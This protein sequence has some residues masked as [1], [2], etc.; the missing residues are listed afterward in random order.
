MWL[1]KDVAMCY[2]SR[3][4]IHDPCAKDVLSALRQA[5]ERQCATARHQRLEPSNTMDVSNCWRAGMLLCFW[6]NAIATCSDAVRTA[7]CRPA[8]SGDQCRSRLLAPVS[9]AAYRQIDRLAQTS[10][11]QNGQDAPSMSHGAMC[12]AGPQTQVGRSTR[13]SPW[14]AESVWRPTRMLVGSRF[15]VSPSFRLRRH[16]CANQRERRLHD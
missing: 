14:H 10:T 9:P 11:A 2:R 1:W 5:V 7:D 13:V 12:S 6:A 16:N 4:A 15:V 3:S 8:K